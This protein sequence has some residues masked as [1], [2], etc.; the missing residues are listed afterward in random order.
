MSGVL[1]NPN[2]FQTV[3]LAGLSA[4]PFDTNYFLVRGQST[5]L[6]TISKLQEEA[7]PLESQRC[8]RSSCEAA[9]TEFCNLQCPP[10]KFPTQH[11]C[12]GPGQ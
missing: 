3:P 11:G 5:A 9:P 12:M 8:R 6:A 1:Q 2:L 10:L 4:G 7:G